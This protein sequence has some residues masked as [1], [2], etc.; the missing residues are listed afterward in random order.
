M[1]LLR[2]PVENVSG[3]STDRPEFV[4]QAV[5][6]AVTWYLGARFRIDE[7]PDI[8]YETH[9]FGQFYAGIR[10]NYSTTNAFA[11]STDNVPY[12]RRLAERLG[13]DELVRTLSDLEAELLSVD[14]E[15]LANFNDA[16]GENFDEIFALVHDRFG[17]IVEG[18]N[19][20]TDQ[21]YPKLL[22]AEELDQMSQE[23]IEAARAQMKAEAAE[24]IRL[25]KTRPFLVAAANLVR[26]SDELVWGDRDVFFDRFSDDLAQ[27]GGY[28][29]RG[30]FPKHLIG[31]NASAY[32][33]KIDARMLTY[34]RA[35]DRKLE[36]RLYVDELRTTK[37]LYWVATFADAV[38]LVE[39]D[40]QRVLAQDEVP[41]IVGAGERW[42]VSSA[43]NW[44][45]NRDTRTVETLAGRTLMERLQGLF[46]GP[47]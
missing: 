25:E 1:K 7:L 47:R 33:Q 41:A 26:E 46:K 28:W 14:P 11:G 36:T 32:L 37:G 8:A 45:L 21:E 39:M 19:L 43:P 9:V 6:D 42:R 17:S 34:F 27:L 3:D 29:D 31:E 30:S 12:A 10:G 16:T 40:T 13:W 20:L 24:F 5:S 44:R 38:Q 22:S 35:S 23:E 15:D 4:L 18:D 2:L